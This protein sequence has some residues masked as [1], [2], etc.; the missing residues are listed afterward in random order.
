[1][2]TEDRLSYPQ[3]NYSCL[4]SHIV[5]LEHCFEVTSNT[6]IVDILS[7]GMG[8]QRFWYPWQNCLA[9]QLLGICQCCFYV[10]LCLIEQSEPVNVCRECVNYLQKKGV[11][12]R[13]RSLTTFCETIEELRYRM[14]LEPFVSFK[15]RE[16]YWEKDGTKWFSRFKQGHFYLR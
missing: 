3:R 15:E 16:L 7:W 14:L 9:N 1:M 2:A 12:S 6:H 8:L 13:K 11:S 5:K 4:L 10:T